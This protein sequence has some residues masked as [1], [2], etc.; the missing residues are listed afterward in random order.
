VTSG[1]AGHVQILGFVVICRTPDTG[2]LG[3]LLQRRRADG[4]VATIQQTV[5]A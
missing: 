5:V 1:N 4:A 2:T 3:E